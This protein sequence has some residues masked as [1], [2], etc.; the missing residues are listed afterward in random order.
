MTYGFWDAVGLSGVQVPMFFV[1]GSIDDVSG[2]DPCIRSL[3]E[4][5]VN[6]DRS[7]LTFD[8]AN[9]NAAAPIPA[10]AESFKTSEGK[11]PTY[12]H[13]AD[14]VWDTVRMNNI[15]Q[16]FVT[17]WLGKYLGGDSVM[18]AYLDLIP[19][20]NDGVFSQ[21]K[22]GS[23]NAEHSHWKGF[24]DRTAKGLRFETLLAAE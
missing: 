24:Q 2:Y 3:W 16:H 6:V 12:D 20:A 10:P 4:G 15:A 9:H 22:D 5:S 19:N 23:F 17:A 7:L 13:Y 14:A 18:A 11:S 8:N 21:N 1:A